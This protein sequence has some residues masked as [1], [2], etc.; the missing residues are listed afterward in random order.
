M[1]LQVSA[2]LVVLVGVLIGLA[3]NPATGQ[4]RW[5][6]GLDVIRRHP[7]P[8]VGVLVA[9]AAALAVAQPLLARGAAQVEGDPDPP[10]APQIPAW[11]VDRDQARQVS[12]V[13]RA[14]RGRRG[15]TVGITT[16][17]LGAG[18]FGKTTVARLVQADPRV[19]RHFRGRVYEI[20]IGREVRGKAEI[21]A[22]VAQ[23]A[24]KITNDTR[25]YEDP[26]EAGQ[27]LGQLLASRPRTLLVLDDVWDADQL[28]PFLI[29]AQD[30]CARLVTTRVPS[31]LSAD[32]VRVVVDRM[33]AQ[34]AR[35]VL[36][37]ELP[38]L[39]GAVV[40]DLLE[41]AEG[42]AILLRLANRAIAKGI[43]RGDS[44]E[45]AA[46]VELRALRDTGPAS[47]DD[48]AA[49]V[50]VDDRDQ[51]ARTVRAT[52][53]ASLTYLPQEGGARARCLELGIF[54]E[55]EAIPAAL[56]VTLWNATGGM[57]ERAARDLCLALEDLALISWD[58]EDG[59][60]VRLHDVVR[61]YLRAE[62]GAGH[63]EAVNAALLDAL[64][65]DLPAAATPDPSLESPRAAWWRIGEGYMMDY[66]IRH[67]LAAGRG[68]Q[69]EAVACD[70]R[71]IRARLDQR[72]PAAPLRDLGQVPTAAAAAR[73][74][75]LGRIAHLLEPTE[76][77]RAVAAILHSRLAPLPAWREQVRA[78]VPDPGDLPALRNLWDPPDLPD[79][80][81]LRTLTG[82][83]MGVWAVAISPD[84]IWLATAD[85]H[86]TVR[87]WEEATGTKTAT[88]TGRIGRVWAVAISPD[89][90]WLATADEHG[91]VRIWEKATGKKTATLTG[92]VMGVWAVAISPDGTWLATA[93]EDGTVRIWEKATGRRVATLTGHTGWVRAVAISP[94]G[95]W[96]ATAGDDRTIRIW[97]KNN[98]QPVASM[99]TEAPVHNCAWADPRTIA[100][101]GEQGLYLYEFVAD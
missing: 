61:D 92:H 72:G 98:A 86:G 73:A 19:R 40:E 50:D 100:A 20:R 97:A 99:R 37:D 54:A 3:A 49:A 90:T 56:V 41:A 29:G 22:K 51:R 57:S 4:A 101:A 84:G 71:W 55:D 94:D 53:E 67:L 36:I 25:V 32:A 80:A 24:R 6:W 46:L 77:A 93:G 91:S 48:P 8:S 10:T 33:S 85:E 83:V 64:A 26:M 23:A 70:L 87:I 12:A 76:P 75:D 28:A 60:W 65:V 59:G 69:A 39:P 79:S 15:R 27:R 44:A 2:V 95:T 9:A 42:W 45:R 30:R 96:L 81:L 66:L 14:R 74:R 1:G 34:Q 16:G 89:G 21:A 62:L 88:L 78:I 63:R 58:R 13:L 31:A 38:V 35:R 52:I 7:F 68:G 43:R 47:V 18:G 11:V 5:P 82:H 17:V